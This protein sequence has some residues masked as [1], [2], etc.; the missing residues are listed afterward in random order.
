MKLKFVFALAVAAVL[1]VGCKQTDAQE[2]TTKEVAVAGKTETAS[3][4][5]EGM[6]CAVGCANTLQK[7]LAATEGVKKATVDFEAK[8]ATVDYDSAVTSPEKLAQVVEKAA[9]GDTYKVANM[10]STAD[11][12]MLNNTEKDKKKKKKSKKNSQEETAPKAGCDDKAPGSKPGCCA[13]KKSCA[14]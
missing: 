4:T 9:G 7:K 10:K 8:L 6:S 13:A 2:T 1:T 5:I 3:F 12:A 14:A 11:K